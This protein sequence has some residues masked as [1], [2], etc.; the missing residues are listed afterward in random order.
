M[1]SGASSG[2][3]MVIGIGN[4]DRGDDAVGLVAARLLRDRLPAEVEVATRSGNMLSLLDDWQGCDTV[5][6]IDAAAPCGTPGRLHCLDLDAA[7]LPTGSRPAACHGLGL[8]HAIALG[9]ALGCVPRCIVIYAIEGASFE[10]GASLT[11]AVSAALAP[12]LEA[13][14]AHIEDLHLSGAGLGG[15]SA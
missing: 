11:P 4:P 10:M 7:E 5:V 6:C 9:R 14:V 13:I 12:A 8:D 3:I 2:R 1:A 15:A